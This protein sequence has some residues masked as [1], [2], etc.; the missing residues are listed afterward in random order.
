MQT[1]S[2]RSF[3]SDNFCHIKRTVFTSPDI[4]QWEKQHIFGRSWLFLAHESQIP[5]INDFVTTFMCE[6]PVIVA[7]GADNQVHVSINSCSHR[8]LPVC[9]ADHGNAKR[10]VCP[11]HSWAYTVEGVLHT[12]PQEKKVERPLDKSCLGL[13]K[14]PRIDS[15]C[16]LIFGSFDQDIEPLASYLGDMRWY[17]DCMFDRYHGGVEVVGAAHKWQIDANWKLPVENQLGDVAHGPYLH[18]SL[19]KG[20]PQVDEL[21]TLGLNMVPKAGHGVAVRLMPEGTSAE[22][23]MWGTDGMAAMDP[24]VNAYLLEKHIEAEERLGKLRARIKP[25]TYSVY[26]N[27]SFLWGNNTIR[28][29]HPR[30]PGQIEYWSWWVVEK[31]APEHIKK[32]L[33]ENYTFFFGPGGVLEQEDSEAW[34]QQHRGCSVDFMDDAP[35]YYGLGA[36]EEKLHAEL[37]GMAGSCFNEHYAR[38]FYSR[39]R[40]DIEAG[41]ARESRT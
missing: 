6:T 40:S 32:K 26:P 2:P 30:G 25:L 18:G 28:V 22:K 5:N 33:R 36:G 39:W 23:S 21:E 41:L 10:F 14:I 31:N 27:F 8:G 11:Y 20:T 19:L 24:E 17:L 29:T 15:Y 7:R 9:R 38:E 35:L 3:V 12:V 37:P 16:G 1:A 34:S 4:Y 13:K